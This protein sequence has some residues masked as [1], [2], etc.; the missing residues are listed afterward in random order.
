MK[1]AELAKLF[2]ETFEELLTLRSKAQKEYAHDEENAFANFE[3]LAKYLRLDR[4][5]I[6]TVY[7]IKHF[8]GI[9]A[10]VNGHESQREDV[11]GRIHDLIV[12]LLI[13][14]GM[15]VEDR[16]QQFLAGKATPPFQA[17]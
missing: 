8:D 12:Y 10:H 5:Q 7:A 6:L 17:D 13:L 15:I 9:I 2:E 1:P 3:R 11:T 4:K 14:K 16:Q